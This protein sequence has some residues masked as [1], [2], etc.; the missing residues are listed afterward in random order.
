MQDD[1]RYLKDI[2][3]VALVCDTM[4]EVDYALHMLS[5]SY[6]NAIVYDRMANPPPTGY[7][8][9]MLVVRS[10]RSHFC[11]IQVH[12]KSYWDAKKYRGDEIYNEI[13]KLG[14]AD[15]LTPAEKK[16]RRALYSESRELYNKAGEPHGFIMQKDVA[17]CIPYVYVP[18]T[19][20]GSM[21]TKAGAMPLVALT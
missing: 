1:P 2:A 16:T 10:D 3:R 14:V 11:E 5:H 6:P 7:R 18:A 13:R 8:D 15:E 12:L 9:K 20:S 21:E 19:K 17:R 4:E